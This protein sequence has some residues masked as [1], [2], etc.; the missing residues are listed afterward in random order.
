MILTRVVAV[1]T[2]AAGCVALAWIVGWI[3]SPTPEYKLGTR[4]RILTGI[5]IA[6]LWVVADI[7]QGRWPW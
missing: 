3:A 1:I 7:I 2:I 4:W 5:A 6:T